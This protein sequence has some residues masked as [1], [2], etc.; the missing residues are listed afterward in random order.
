MYNTSGFVLATWLIHFSESYFYSSTLPR[1]L[2]C[3]KN[4]LSGFSFSSRCR[5]YFSGR[6]KS[7]TADII[8]LLHSHCCSENEWPFQCEFA[9]YFSE[10]KVGSNAL[11]ENGRPFINRIELL[12]G[13][14]HF[15]LLFSINVFFLSACFL[16][17]LLKLCLFEVLISLTAAIS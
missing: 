10:M 15:H 4:Q 17:P 9:A 11:N 5:L 12:S 2:H 3:L 7:T 1:F 8:Q 13:A 6:H 14:P 16:P